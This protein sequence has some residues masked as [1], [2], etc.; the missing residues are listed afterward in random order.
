MLAVPE[1]M[2]KPNLS[3]YAHLRVATKYP[4]CA[5]SYFL[6]LGIQNEIIKLNGSIELAPMVGLSE[7]IVD[8]VE[9]GATLKENNLVV[10]EEIVP[11]STRLI[12]NKASYKF[13]YGEID[14]I[15]NELKKGGRND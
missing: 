6:G 8:I 15:V 10:K 11:V 1:H 2:Q 13:K 7:L 5:K 12:A 14:S 3:D 9:T 4:N